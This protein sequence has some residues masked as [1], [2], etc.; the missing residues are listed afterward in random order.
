MLR[1]HHHRLLSAVLAITLSWASQA[2]AYSFSIQRSVTFEPGVS[3]ISNQDR[4]DIAKTVIDANNSVAR[5]GTVVIYGLADA[6]EAA[7]NV[8]KA[9]AI[10]EKR[11]ESVMAY[12]RSLGVSQDRFAVDYRAFTFALDIPASERYQVLVEFIPASSPCG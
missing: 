1:I 6:R 10:T 9:K 12:L 5:T 8:D 11:V 4:V 2:Y 3:S 7:K